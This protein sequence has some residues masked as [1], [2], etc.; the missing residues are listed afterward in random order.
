[1]NIECHANKDLYEK[2]LK[3]KKQGIF[4]GIFT[5]PISLIAAISCHYHNNPICAYIFAFQCGA[6]CAL[7]A[8]VI[9]QYIKLIR[10]S[11]E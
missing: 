5:I 4:L 11:H 3:I 10:Y 2:N 1:M 8:I 6:L 9:R 7:T